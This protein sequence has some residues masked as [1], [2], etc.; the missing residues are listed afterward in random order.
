MDSS[1]VRSDSA[2]QRA[3][4]SASAGPPQPPVSTPEPLAATQE[5]VPSATPGWQRL[6]THSYR[7]GL[8]WLVTG[9]RNGWRGRRVGLTR[10]LV[11]LDPWRYYELGRVA[12][13][14]FSGRC[15]DVSSPKLL[16]SLLQHERCGEW[17][18]VDLFDE[19]I[20]NWRHVDPVLDLRVEDAT[21]LSFAGETF[22]NCICVSVV[23]HVPG[24]GD[25]TAMAEIWRVLKKGGVLHLTTDVAAE[26]REI[27]AGEKVYGAASSEV[28]GRVFFARH[29]GEHDLE[30]R[31]LGEPWEVVLREFARQ[32]DESIERAFYRRAP[33]S[34]LYGG[35]LRLRCADN[36]EV[37]DAP[38]FAAESEHSVVYLRLRKPAG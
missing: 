2:T 32:R 26:P 17:I 31:L 19:E 12:D 29:Y 35:L 34:Y 8:R 16:A 21:K 38:V 3:G 1:S 24:D 20:E 5:P 30:Q 6:W 4:V 36:F 18:A 33:W 10:L 23:E 13:A 9:A 11:P 7:L 14:E 15:L 22:D 37:T 25:M 27:F 28:D